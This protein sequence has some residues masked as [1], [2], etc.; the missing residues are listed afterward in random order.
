[1]MCCILV[2]VANTVLDGSKNDIPF[3]LSTLDS[4]DSK[5]AFI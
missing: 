3:E 2:N 5:L 4:N 1:M